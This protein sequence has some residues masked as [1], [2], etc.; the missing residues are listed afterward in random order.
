[1]TNGNR[2]KLS[3]QFLNIFRASRLPVLNNPIDV[4]EDSID[5]TP[6]ANF[7]REAISCNFMNNYGSDLMSLFILLGIVLVLACINYLVCRLKKK[8]LSMYRVLYLILFLPN[9]LV[10]A[11]MFVAVIDG[12]HIEITRLAFINLIAA[13]SSLGQIVGCVLSVGLLLFYCA[14]AWVLYRTCRE[15]SAQG[16][17]TADSKVAKMLAFNFKEFKAKTKHSITYYTPVMIIAKNVITQLVLVLLGDT[18]LWQLYMLLAVE[19]AGVGLTVL[20][21]SSQKG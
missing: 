1:M 13:N 21:T 16:K 4:S 8:H 10:N 17:L 14:Y 20:Q 19:V 7:A 6:T 18:N 9:A 3:D 15:F 5:C 12:S 11:E 2:T